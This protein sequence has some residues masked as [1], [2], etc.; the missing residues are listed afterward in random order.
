MAASA[1]R[2]A[3]KLPSFCLDQDTND[4]GSLRGKRQLAI[5]GRPL[6]T[7]LLKDANHLFSECSE[8]RVENDAPISP[9]L[10]RLPDSGGVVPGI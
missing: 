6:L 3:S 7:P 9:S 2:H 4:P 1:R 5:F 8:R 10:S